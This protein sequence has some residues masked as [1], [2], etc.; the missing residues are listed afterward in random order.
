[1][2]TYRKLGEAVSV[3]GRVLEGEA[4]GVVGE[5]GE[6]R[7]REAAGRASLCAARVSTSGRMMGFNKLGSI[8]N[9]YEGMPYKVTKTI[10]FRILAA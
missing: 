10:L 5:R 1:M 6:V 3:L 8:M 7:R 2:E 4:D 9:D